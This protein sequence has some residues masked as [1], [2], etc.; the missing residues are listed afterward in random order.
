[1]WQVDG[2]KL[3]NTFPAG[4]DYTNNFAVS[5]DAR[6]VLIGGPNYAKLVRISD[7][8]VLTKLGSGW[9]LGVA[10]LNSDILMVR[11]HS[12]LAFWSTDGKLLCDKTNLDGPNVAMS[13]HGALAVGA[14]HQRDIEVWSATEVRQA[15]H[16]N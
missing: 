3:L 13:K 15:C 1:M 16:L 12:R 2:W 7:G 14:G 10:Y 8:S 4:P 9:V 6:T 5:P 11:D